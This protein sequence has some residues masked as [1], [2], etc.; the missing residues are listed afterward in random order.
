[1]MSSEVLT[2]ARIFD[3]AR[4]IEGH[5]LVLES[6]E[7]AAILPEAEAPQTGRRAVEGILAF[8]A[9]S[10]KLRMLLKTTPGAQWEVAAV[11]RLRLKEAFD[12]AGVSIAL[13]QLDVHL[14]KAF[15]SVPNK[16][17]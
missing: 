3:G 14:P 6:G 5:A 7:I 8:D 13:P 10:L 16:M 2:G 1:M 4:M 11:Y 17:A 12:R 15:E 9:S